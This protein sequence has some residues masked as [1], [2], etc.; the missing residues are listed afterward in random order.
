MD[1]LDVQ[2]DWGNSTS[3]LESELARAKSEFEALNRMLDLTDTPA[4]QD[5][6][7]LSPAALR[8]ISS[9]RSPS[10]SGVSSGRTAEQMDELVDELEDDPENLRI[11]LSQ[12]KSRVVEL[13]TELSDAAVRSSRELEQHVKLLST[14][15][16]QSLPN[17]PLK[18][19]EQKVYELES[20][21]EEQTEPS[22]LL[23]QAQQKVLLEIARVLSRRSAA[24][25]K[26]MVI[27]AHRAVQEI[28][29]SAAKDKT[30]LAETQQRLEQSQTEAQLRE[31]AMKIKIIDDMRQAAIERR[32][33]SSTLAD[34]SS[35]L[36]V[37]SDSGIDMTDVTTT[38]DIGERLTLDDD[39]RSNRL[40]CCGCN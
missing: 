34:I 30:L 12:V 24:N 35:S 20:K 5:S 19:A 33:A 40:C 39:D 21:L 29:E 16:E 9:F 6:T 7:I 22:M 1:E 27:E 8:V 32:S 4:E 2:F 38:P 3:P 28:S 31:A 26:R 10:P 15:M 14:V 11:M 37:F 17:S 18:Q 25:N 23:E 13:E 36:A